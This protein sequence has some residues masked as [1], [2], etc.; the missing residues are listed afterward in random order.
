VIRGLSPTE[1]RET[2]GI[3][4]RLIYDTD[5]ISIWERDTRTLAWGFRRKRRKYR[6]FALKE[7]APHALAADQAPHAFDVRELFVKSG[8]KGF[9]TEFFLPPFGDASYATFTSSLLMSQALKAEEFCAADGGLG[10]AL[11][12]HELGMAPLLVSGNLRAIFK[13]MLKIY[14]EI[15]SG[16]PAIAAFAITEPGAG[17]DVEDTE[18]AARAK[19]GCRA[20][21]V[22]GG[23]K[24]SGRKVFISD[25]AVAR[26]VTLFAAQEDQGAESWTCFLLDKSMPGLTVG[27]SERKMGQRAADAS[28]LVLEDVFVPDE[29]VIGKPGAGWAINRNVLNYSRPIVGAIAL[30]IARGAFEHAVAF[31]KAARLANRPLLQ[32]SDVQVALADMMMKIAAMRAT[33]WHAMSHRVPFQTAGSIAKV[34]C[35]DTSW[36]VCNQALDLLGNHGALRRNSVE[37]AARDA[38]LTQ[39][40][41]GTNQINRLAIFE[42]Q[43]GSDF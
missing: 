9:Q 22:T 25:G 34:F 24:V 1:A 33:I 17:S 13:W 6:E 21:K 41:E 29:R 15:K 2:L 11:L 42:S 35:A 14:G 32:C 36:E 4:G 20:K 7:I 30:G 18:G 38:R 23:W 12:A 26:W 3:L 16:E 27:R 37:K 31:C 10:L 8:L 19:L 40:Y 39:I 5:P 28:E 43:T